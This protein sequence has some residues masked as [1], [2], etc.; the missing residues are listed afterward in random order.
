MIKKHTEG[1][2]E[3]E[4]A[5]G[6]VFEKEAVEAT[7]IGKQWSTESQTPATATIQITI[8]C[9][10]KQPSLRSTVLQ[11]VQFDGAYALSISE[12]HEC[13]KEARV[14]RRRSHRMG[15]VVHF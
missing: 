6:W 9:F 10:T 12:A 2:E 1:T 7:V 4:E 5:E 11:G 3:G 8:F 13:L 14:F 15:W